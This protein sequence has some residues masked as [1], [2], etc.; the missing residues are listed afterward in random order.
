MN[1]RGSALRLV[2]WLLLFVSS[3]PVWADD[4]LIAERAAV[5]EVDDG[6]D[7]EDE[8]AKHDPFE[9]FN[10]AV[11]TFNE[12]VDRLAFRPL[13]RGYVRVTPAPARVGVANFLG[14]LFSPQTIVND[15]LQG[16]FQQGMADL[17]RLII[18]LTVGFG[19]IFDPAREMGLVRHSEDFGQTLAVWGIDTS[20]YLVLPI[21]GPSTLRDTAGRVVDYPLSPL[22]YADSAEATTVGFVGAINVRANLLQLD[23]LLEESFD[24]YAFQR[25]GWMSLRNAAIQR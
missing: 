1:L 18:N 24:P 23:R 7:D 14:T 21:M 2:L 9:P 13:A 11:F 25:E 20:P 22:S 17:G 19:G 5:I 10:R 3:G 15:F 6:E 4:A 8:S 16:K 12:L